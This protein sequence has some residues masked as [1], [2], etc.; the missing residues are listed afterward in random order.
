MSVP[1]AKQDCIFGSGE[2]RHLLN[3]TS[4]KPVTALVRFYGHFVAFQ[5]RT[6]GHGTST[7]TVSVPETGQTYIYSDVALSLPG[8]ISVGSLGSWSDYSA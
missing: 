6:Y 7:F 3:G 2:S 4:Y 1:D 5:L 8:W